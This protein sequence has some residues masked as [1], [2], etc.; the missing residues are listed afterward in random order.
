MA[1]NAFFVDFLSAE[2]DKGNGEIG[3]HP[4][5]WNNPPA[6]NLPPPANS[7]D[8][9]QPY[10]IEYPVSVM[11]QKFEILYDLLRKKFNT[12]IIAHRAGRWA[13]NQDY[14]NILAD[15]GLKID[16]S[17]TPHVSWENA[18]GL[19]YGSRGPDYSKYPENPYIVKTDSAD[20]LEIP[21]TIRRLRTLPCVNGARSFLSGIK[22][23][24]TG[25]TVWLRP[26]GSN[27][28]DMLALIDAIQV[29][30]ADYLMFMLHS[31]ELMPGGS[32]VFKTPESIEYLY[33]NLKVIFNKIADNFKG[34]TI[35]D[36]YKS[37]FQ[38]SG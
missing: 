25:K 19:S 33:D 5:A 11:R 29:S 8:C 4:H 7:R 26:N 22:K 35:Q 2:L 37:V 1:N 32:P 12:D 6:Y 3:L 10:L 36:Y 20:V 23:F 31:S 27:L 30:D 24:I 14:F 18:Y 15:Y 34:I 38:L 9:G 21:V 13:M 28:S 16:C 17:I